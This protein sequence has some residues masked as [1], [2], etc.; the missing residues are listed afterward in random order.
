MF[1]ALLGFPSS[2]SRN[3]FNPPYIEPSCRHSP[4]QL[5]NE[6]RQSRTPGQ[7]NTL[8]LLPT[9]TVGSR[10]ENGELIVERG[11][12]DVGPQGSQLVLCRHLPLGRSQAWRRLTRPT[13]SFS[14][15]ES[16]NGPGS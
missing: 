10:V 8:A 5:E 12:G 4:T 6:F 1:M 14:H 3:Q 2:G 16:E 11:Q 13:N 15:L 9:T 7:M